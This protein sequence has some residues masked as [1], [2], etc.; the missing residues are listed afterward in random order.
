MNEGLVLT[1]RGRDIRLKWHCLRRTGEEAVFLR[2]NLDAGLALGASIEVDI[3]QL[4]DG[5]FVCLHDDRLESETDGH[6]PVAEAD[7]ATIRALRVRGDGEAPLLLD[8]VVAAIVDG[9]KPTMPGLMI[10]LDLKDDAARLSDNGVAGF[11]RLIE[12]VASAFILSAE[13]WPAVKHLGGEVPNLALG[14]DPWDLAEQW[15]FDG[16]DS[17]LRFR[18]AAFDI[19]PEAEGMYLYKEI[20]AAGLR[21]DVN[22]VAAFQERG[23]W[24]DCWTIDAGTPGDDAYL[25]AALAAGVDQITTNTPRRLAESPVR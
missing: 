20:V 5:H 14:Y 18:D 8:D 16:H 11:A 9:P 7:A 17:F 13:N 1:H 3:Q 21:Q 22:V 2:A 10:Q 6:G 4:A 23:V 19:A 25:A 12:P 15:S 24:V